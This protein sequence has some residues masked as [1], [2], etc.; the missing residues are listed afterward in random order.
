MRPTLL[1][2]ICTKGGLELSYRSVLERIIIRIEKDGCIVTTRYDMKS[3]SYDTNIESDIIRVS[4]KDV[5]EPLNIIWRL[6]HEYGHY[7]S[8]RAKVGDQKMQREDLAWKHADTLVREYPELL[9]RIDDY[10][11]CKEQDLN[12]YRRALCLI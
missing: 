10:E 3:S 8:G 11:R 1:D 7:L 12:S 2:E 9:P 5:E 4:L 6:L